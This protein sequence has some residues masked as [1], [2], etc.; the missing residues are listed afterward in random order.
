ML[1]LLVFNR[2][3]KP[4]ANIRHTVGA[5]S[6]AHGHVRDHISKKKIFEKLFLHKIK[7]VNSAAD[8]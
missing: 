7:G 2:I 6:I 3:I 5:Q 1:G 8:S 4:G